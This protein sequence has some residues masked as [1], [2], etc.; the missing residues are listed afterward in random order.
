MTRWKPH[1]RQTTSD[2]LRPKRYISKILYFVFLVSCSVTI[3]N[4]LAAALDKLKSIAVW[5]KKISP[6]G[7]TQSM[8]SRVRSHTKLRWQSY[9]SSRVLDHRL[10]SRY[11]F[12]N[13]NS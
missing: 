12:R 7:L 2:R 4:V 3:R 13:A 9:E 8:H 1:K 11:H 5:L 10:K 6:Y